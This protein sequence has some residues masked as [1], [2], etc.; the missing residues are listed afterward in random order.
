MDLISYPA[1]SETRRKLLALLWRDQIEGDIR[2]LASLIGAPYAAAYRELARMEGAGLVL[3]VRRGRRSVL[4]RNAEYP[5]R[6]ALRSLLGSPPNDEGSRAASGPAGAPP[7][8]RAALADDEK[9]RAELAALGAPLLIAKHVD[10]RGGSGIGTPMDHVADPAATLVAG[11]RLARVDP[12][13]A[14]SLPI[15]IHR[16]WDAVD[17]RKLAFYAG[18]AGETQTLGFFLDLTGML[19]RRPALREAARSYRDRRVRRRRE[20]FVT[21]KL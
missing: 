9:T 2:Q 8:L 7:S 17:V 11:L 20:F 6:E 18:V 12:S 19:A 3:R 13:V 4:S 16:S 10:V 21:L 15:A 1:P 5:Q 14:R